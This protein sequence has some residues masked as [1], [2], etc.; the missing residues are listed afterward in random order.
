MRGHLPLLSR[1]DVLPDNRDNVDNDANARLV[2][3]DCL[4]T[5]M[6]GNAITLRP[7]QSF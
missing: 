1:A 7:V 5:A 2:E 6:V 4:V 3:V